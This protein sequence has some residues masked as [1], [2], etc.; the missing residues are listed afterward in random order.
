MH[1]QSCLPS[2]RDWK[3][4]VAQLCF[5]RLSSRKGQWICNGNSYQLGHCGEKMWWISNCI[6]QN[7]DVYMYLQALRCVFCISYTVLEGSR[8]ESIIT[9]I[10]P[11][12]NC[13]PLLLL[14]LQWRWHT[15]RLQ[16]QVKEDGAPIRTAWLRIAGPLCCQ[17]RLCI[18]YLPSTLSTHILLHGWIT[19]CLT[20]VL[21]FTDFSW[22]QD[23]GKRQ[24][25]GALGDCPLSSFHL[26]ISQLYA[27]PIFVGTFP[28]RH[29]ELQG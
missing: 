27:T 23:D 16:H 13:S 26:P 6:M 21:F 11:T 18:L 9:V 7:T 10:N 1:S 19:L 24:V 29:N 20:C 12:D 25:Y 22:H 15:D 4:R 28:Y 3:V 17:G 14:L 8:L 5:S 2:T